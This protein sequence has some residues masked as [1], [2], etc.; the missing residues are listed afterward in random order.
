MPRRI[1]PKNVTELSMCEIFVFGSNL[2]GHHHG[3]AARTAHERFG[4]EWGVGSGP[5]GQCY[6]IPT[7][8]GGVADIKPYV[9]EFVEY[10]KAHPNNRFLVTRVWHSRFYR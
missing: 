7:M 8:H 4:A 6:A 10:A 9:D 3:G 1:T 5:T 2:Q